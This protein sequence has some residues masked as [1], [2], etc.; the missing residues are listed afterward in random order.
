MHRFSILLAN[1]SR[2]TTLN[3]RPDITAL[4]ANADLLDH[5][6]TSHDHC[7]SPGFYSFDSSMKT[8][9]KTNGLS[10]LTDAV[11]PLKGWAAFSIQTK[12]D[13]FSYVPYDDV[14]IK[15]VAEAQSSTHTHIPKYS[16][17]K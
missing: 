3:H 9:M 8:Q 5:S 14:I 17:F 16:T 12:T 11:I 10:R 2:H 4:P 6:A 13:V 1:G 15:S 7:A